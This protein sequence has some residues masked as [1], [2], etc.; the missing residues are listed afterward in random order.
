MFCSNCGKQIDD[1]VVNC[2]FCSAETGVTPA[3]TE[4]PAAEQTA[5]QA[6]PQYEQTYGQQNYEQQPYQPYQTQSYQPP[7]KS[8]S[9]GLAIAGFICAF[10][11]PLLGLIFSCIG[12]NHSKKMGGDGKGL[13]I[14]GIVI[15][16]LAIV[17][18]IIYLSIFIAAIVTLADEETWENAI[19]NALAAISVIQ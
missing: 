14:A 16:V 13:S 6:Q 2:P 1:N 15:S 12:L 5:Q 3:Q 4:E 7:R 17:I 11:F 9:N 10:F 18:I 8:G 19:N